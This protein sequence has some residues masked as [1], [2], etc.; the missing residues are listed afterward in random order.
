MKTRTVFYIALAMLLAAGPIFAGVTIIANP[1]VPGTTIS[2]NDLKEIFLGKRVKWS[3]N[4]RI[5][6]VL[7][8]D[9]GTHESFLKNYVG[10][11]TSQFDMHWRNMIFTGQGRAPTKLSSDQ[12]VIN[13]VASTPGAVGY[14]SSQP[15][16]G[17]IK[18]L[19]VR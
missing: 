1:S 17:N 2:E 18:T 13:F 12:D 14:V 5:N 6:F 3:D 16:S 8:K 7:S 15:G 11:S 4:S 10:R 9:Y 19:T